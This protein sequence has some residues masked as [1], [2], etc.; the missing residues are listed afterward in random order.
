LTV[1][2]DSNV[3]TALVLDDHRAKAI[4]PIPPWL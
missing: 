1:V 2:L 3:V 4:E